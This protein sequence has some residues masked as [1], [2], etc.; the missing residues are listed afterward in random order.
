M[1]MVKRFTIKL[2]KE[3]VADIIKQHFAE[4]TKDASKVDVQFDVRMRTVGYGMMEHAEA[5]LDDIIVEVQR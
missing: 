1:K 5:V 4:E 3:E 2:T